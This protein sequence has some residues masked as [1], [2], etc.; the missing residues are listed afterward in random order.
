MTVNPPSM[1]K[2]QDGRP[3]NKDRIPSTGEGKIKK[4][5]D[6]CQEMGH[7]RLNCPSITPKTNIESINKVLWNKDF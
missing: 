5:C 1:L 7:T 6:R 3:K 2:R 4:K